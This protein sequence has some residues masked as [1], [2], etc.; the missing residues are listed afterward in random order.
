MQNPN[1]QSSQVRLASL[2]LP[3]SSQL[4]AQQAFDLKIVH[5]LSPNF[6]SAVNLIVLREN[7]QIS[8]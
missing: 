7:I 3:P 5:T 6:V 1:T 2:P 8:L 4:S